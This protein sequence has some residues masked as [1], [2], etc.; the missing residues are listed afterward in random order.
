MELIH[1]YIVLEALGSEFNDFTY[2]PATGTRGGILLAWKSR[3]VTISDPLFTTNALSA[4]VS[5]TNTPPWWISVVY[6]PQDDE[7]KIAFLDELRHVRTV[8]PALGCYAATLTSYTVM[9]TKTT[10]TSTG[11]SWGSSDAASTTLPS[12]KST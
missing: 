11:A 8:S 10:E 2:L 4:K 5:M 1:S 9:R 3:E 12:R 6:G 7:A